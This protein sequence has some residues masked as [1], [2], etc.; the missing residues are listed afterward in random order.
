M[1]YKYFAEKFIQL[2]PEYEDE[3]QEHIR[4]CGEINVLVFFGDVINRPLFELLKENQ[5]VELIQKYI[6]FIED[7]YANGDADVKNVVE[8][9][10]LEYL[11]DDDMVLKNIFTYFSENLMQASKKIEA[12]WGRRNI[13]IWYRRGKVLAD[14]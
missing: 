7:M 10:I 1:D 12:L 6:D 8:V 13:H 14:W 11:S 9:I 5:N 3:Y 2:F 4:Y